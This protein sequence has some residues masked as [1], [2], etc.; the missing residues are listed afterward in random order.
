LI[1]NLDQKKITYYYLHANKLRS[2]L[3]AETSHWWSA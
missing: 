2:S 1:R 3:L